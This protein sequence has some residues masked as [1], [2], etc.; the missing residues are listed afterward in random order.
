MAFVSVPRM[1]IATVL[2]SYMPHQNI[3]AIIFSSLHKDDAI[4]PSSGH[5]M[6][7]NIIAFYNTTKSRVDTAT[8]SMK[9][10]QNF[11]F[12]SRTKYETSAKLSMLQLLIRC[13]DLVN[14]R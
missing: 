8:L 3:N 7:K 11:Q 6:K 13:L 14:L 5:Q 2:V 9:R 1:H 12:S 4:G 10:M